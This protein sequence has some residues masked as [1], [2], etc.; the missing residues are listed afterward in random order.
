M[1]LGGWQA[2]LQVSRVMSDGSVS[3]LMGMSG[4]ERHP[5]LLKSWK[6]VFV[7]VVQGQ[8]QHLLLSLLAGVM[9]FVLL[10]LASCDLIASF[11]LP[12]SVKIQ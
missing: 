8:L 5:A 6:D 4:Y 3:I 1:I 11:R 7:D 9:F 10:R 12:A 2:H